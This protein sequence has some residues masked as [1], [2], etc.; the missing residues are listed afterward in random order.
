MT[1]RKKDFS[2][3]WMRQWDAPMWYTITTMPHG[4]YPPEVQ[5]RAPRG[6]FGFCFFLWEVTVV[7]HTVL[8][9]LL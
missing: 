2:S 4:L 8:E 7:H 5:D 3:S 1:P 9:P 6:L